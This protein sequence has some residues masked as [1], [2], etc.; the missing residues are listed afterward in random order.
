MSLFKTS[1]HAP[2][3]LVYEMVF[4]SQFQPQITKTATTKL[5]FTEEYVQEIDCIEFPELSFF[6][7]FTKTNIS[8]GE[9]RRNVSN[10]DTIDVI[11]CNEFGVRL[12]C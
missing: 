9:Q 10:N 8:N 7:V 6:F 1:T 4:N 5:F 12:Y 3:S 2:Y 11:H